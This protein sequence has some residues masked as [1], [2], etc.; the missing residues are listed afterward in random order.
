MNKKY[1]IKIIQNY[2]RNKKRVE[3]IRDSYY[4]IG[5]V[6]YSE[7]N[8]KNSKSWDKIGIQVHNFL[9][10]EEVQQLQKEID[11]VDRLELTLTTTEL[12]V[13]KHFIKTRNQPHCLEH[14]GIS[15][16]NIYRIRN[17]ILFKLKEELEV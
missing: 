16:R 8:Q 15:R 12:L 4:S 6:D 5:A 2:D 13:Y 11:A 9:E 7:S 14:R 1:L 10:N 17:L 3:Q